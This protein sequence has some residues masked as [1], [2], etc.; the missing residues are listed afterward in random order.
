[1]LQGAIYLAINNGDKYW[2]QIGL[3]PFNTWLNS[4]DRRLQEECLYGD[5]INY[6]IRVCH[7]SLN[8]SQKPLILTGGE[9]PPGW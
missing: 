2:N 6:F 7:Y 9:R 3:I 5:K 8:P 4:S 1:M